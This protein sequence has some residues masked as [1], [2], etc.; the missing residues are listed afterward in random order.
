MNAAHLLPLLP[1][2][3]QPPPAPQ[4]P[5]LV[6]ARQAWVALG[7]SERQLARITVPNGDLPVV[8]VGRVRRYAVVDL[9]AW[10]ERHKRTD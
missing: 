8:Y 2:T 7:I 3:P 10:I 9:K 4:F 1:P 5:L 6:D